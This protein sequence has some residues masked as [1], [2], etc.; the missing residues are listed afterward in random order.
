MKTVTFRVTGFVYSVFEKEQIKL[1]V[2]VK[3]NND[4]SPHKLSEMVEARFKTHYKDFY[5]DVNID[6][7]E[8]E[9]ISIEELS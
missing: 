5:P 3:S 1:S 7:I 9:I 6:S 4:N 8:T 2:L